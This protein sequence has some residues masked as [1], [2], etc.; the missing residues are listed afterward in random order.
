MFAK[1]QGR[2]FPCVCIC[3]PSHAFLF[4]HACI[5]TRAT[6]RQVRLERDSALDST[7]S[8]Q[9]HQLLDLIEKADELLQT[10]FML[11]MHSY[12]VRILF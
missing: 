6:L 8:E 1:T 3:A 9:L 11:L 7:S 4:T 10:E 2:S 12:E 5:R